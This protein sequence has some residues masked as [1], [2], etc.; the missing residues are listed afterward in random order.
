MTCKWHQSIDDDTSIYFTSSFSLEYSHWEWVRW[1]ID[2][3]MIRDA[4]VIRALPR[5]MC[6]FTVNCRLFIFAWLWNR[7]STSTL[8][9]KEKNIS[10]HTHA[11]SSI[12]HFFQSNLQTVQCSERLNSCRHSPA[13]T[14]PND[15]CMCRYVFVWTYLRI[16]NDHSS[17]CQHLILDDV[18]LRI[19]VRVD[20]IILLLSNLSI[21]RESW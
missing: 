19:D 1:I 13:W 17:F 3:S 7:P 8:I 16:R 5:S 12:N 9:I 21:W 6:D 14:K 20:L 15:V 2:I 11:R 10:R 18:L 4:D